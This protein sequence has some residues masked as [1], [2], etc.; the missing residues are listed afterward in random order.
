MTTGSVLPN[1]MIVRRFSITDIHSVMR[2]VKR[3]LGET[4]P[5]SLYLTIHNMWPD[6]FMIAEENGQIVGFVAAVESEKRVA[7]VLMFA[8]LPEQRGRSC[9]STLLRKLEDCC[10]AGAFNA[11]K[12][13]V[14][15][16]NLSALSFYERRGFSVTGEIKNFYLNGEDAYQMMKVLQS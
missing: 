12:L 7:R 14:R 9:G 6:G 8:V 3:S 10:L 4:Y 2:V 1:V 5:P 13:E 15:K 16:S 11:I